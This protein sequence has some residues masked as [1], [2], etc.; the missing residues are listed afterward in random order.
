MTTLNGMEQHQFVDQAVEFVAVIL[1]A[2]GRA[3]VELDVS[4]GQDTSIC[5]QHVN[6]GIFSHFWIKL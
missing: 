2:G 6:V 5:V 1:V 3:D 4:A